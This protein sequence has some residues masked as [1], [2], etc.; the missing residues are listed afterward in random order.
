MYTFAITQNLDKY[1][2]MVFINNEEY[3]Y[4]PDL[5]RT[6]CENQLGMYTFVNFCNSKL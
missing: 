4:I 6:E 1:N 3:A 2:L 5:T